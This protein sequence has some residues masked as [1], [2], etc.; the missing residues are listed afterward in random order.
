[1]FLGR[2]ICLAH[3]NLK[4]AWSFKTLISPRMTLKAMILVMFE[5]FLVEFPYFLHLRHLADYYSYL[6]FHDQ[7]N[8]V[9]QILQNKYDLQFLY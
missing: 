5:K 3:D 1:M 4:P 9:L 2:D 7:G 6:C 8:S